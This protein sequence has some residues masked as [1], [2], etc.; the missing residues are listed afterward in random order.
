VA[1]LCALV[2]GVVCVWLYRAQHHRVAL[3]LG[4]QFLAVVLVPGWYLVQ[5]SGEQE[6]D[7]LRRLIAGYAPIYAEELE[8][9]GHARLPDN[10]SADDPLYLTLL[11]MEKRWLASNPNVADIYTFRQLP[12]G[13]VVMLVDSETDYNRNQQYDGKRE[14]RTPPGEPY[15]NT[16]PQLLRAFAYGSSEIDGPVTDRW[17]TWISANVPMRNERGEIEAVLGVDYPAQEWLQ[18]IAEARLATLCVLGVVILILLAALCVVSLQNASVS[19][20]RQVAEA[21]QRSLTEVAEARA[22]LETQATQLQAKNQQLQSARLLAESAGRAKSEFLANMSHE[23]RT[24]MTAILGYTDLLLED[25]TAPARIS[26]ARTIQRNGQ[27]LLD[28]IN[29]VLDLSKIEA[30]K[31]TLDLIPCQASHILAEVIALMS[32]RAEA[33]GLTLTTRS[34]DRLPT[35]VISDPTRLRQ[36]LINLIGNAIKF[37]EQGGVGIAVQALGIQDNRV[38]IEFAVIDSGIGLT[39]EERERLFVPFTQADSSMTRRFGGTGLGLTI[40]QRLA[41]ILGGEI[42]VETRP[43]HGSTF[44]LRFIAEIA[45]LPEP[46][47]AVPAL[48]ASAAQTLPPGLNILLAEDGPDNQRLIA[49]MLRKAG[50]Q[51]AVADHGLKALEAIETLATQGQAFDVI[52]MDM[53]MPVMDGYTATATLR[54]RGYTGIVIALT[55]HAMQGD[56]EKCLEAGCSH[57][58]TKPIDRQRLVKTIVAA[59]HE[60]ERQHA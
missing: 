5:A 42:T 34:D 8:R 4:W 24:P 9:L 2:W 32:V 40:S 35:A 44:R 29:D 1:T 58:A 45:A 33:K 28:I 50:A 14:G 25:E 26:A 53:Q 56:R 27:H 6:A 7:R 20:Y 22:N 36:I 3:L 23:I 59:L 49:M 57:F 55:A 39:H 21:L 52:L 37:T 15:P 17:G 38:E 43:R 48:V 54:S 18:S 10:P 51:V 11:Q 60:S 12:N 31:L 30:N 47:V 41:Q 46:P 19:R 16:T 13:Q